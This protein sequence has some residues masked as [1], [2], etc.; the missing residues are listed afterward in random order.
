MKKTG[1][2][3]DIPCELSFN[4][5]TTTK[6]RIIVFVVKHCGLNMVFLHVNPCHSRCHSLRSALR[7]TFG[8]AST[9]TGGRGFGGSKIVSSETDHFTVILFFFQQL[10]FHVLYSFFFMFFCYHLKLIFVVVEVVLLKETPSTAKDDQ[11]QPR[12][13]VNA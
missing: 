2:Y 4:V 5:M 12:A 6:I 3:L 7:T 9:A 1:E 10:L 13:L 11:V 8:A